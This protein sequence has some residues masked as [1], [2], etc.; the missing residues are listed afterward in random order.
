MGTADTTPGGR[1][2]ALLADERR[3]LLAGDLAQL[4]IFIAG[5]EKL[6]ALLG[7]GPAD[8]EEL[9]RL[10]A[11]AGTN[12]ALIDAALRGV[13]AARA[14]IEVARGGGP[15]LS[16]YDASGKA[17]THGAQASNLERRA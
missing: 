13:R 5:K 9:A 4:P 1:L 11:A 17:A 6:L 3:A 16:T 10:R 15:A 8:A 2:L 7:T 14:R 12:Q